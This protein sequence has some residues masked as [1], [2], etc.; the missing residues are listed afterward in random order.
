M[1]PFLFDSIVVAST[2]SYPWLHSC[3][4]CVFVYDSKT[5]APAYSSSVWLVTD[6]AMS[7]VSVVRWQRYMHGLRYDTDKSLWH[8][9]SRPLDSA[10]EN[11]S[12]SNIIMI[13]LQ[14]MVIA[15]FDVNLMVSFP[16]WIMDRYECALV[17][18]V[19]PTPDYEDYGSSKLN[20]FR[21]YI[22]LLLLYHKLWKSCRQREDNTRAQK[23]GHQRA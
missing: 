14:Q 11:L 7:P 18:F 4:F 13:S 10:P 12:F 21:D 15:Y 23:C 19:L 5:T 6:C 2:L 17:G 20:R 16:S 8:T 1:F 22:C 3:S 9:V